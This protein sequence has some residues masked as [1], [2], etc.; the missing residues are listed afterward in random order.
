MSRGLSDCGRLGDER[1]DQ[2]SADSPS[3][4]VG[5]EVV[6]EVRDSK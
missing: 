5:A 2:Y 4:G 3:I 1:S 6:S